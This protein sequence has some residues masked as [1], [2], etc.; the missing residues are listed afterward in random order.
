MLREMMMAAFS[1]P[2]EPIAYVT[3]ATGSALSAGST[4]VTVPAHAA[5]DM[6]IAF[7]AGQSGIPAV[8]VGWTSIATVSSTA[9]RHGRAV[10]KIGSGNSE[11]V[12]FASGSGSS[13]SS[14]SSVVVLRN[15]LGIGAVAVAQNNN[16]GSTTITLPALALQDT[17]GKSMV[18]G[19]NFSAAVTGAGPD[20]VVSG[21]G[22]WR[23]VTSF[24]ATTV[25]VG[26]SWNPIGYSI[27]LL[28]AGFPALGQVVFT[29]SGTWTPPPGVTSFCAVAVQRGGAQGEANASKVTV[30]GT[31][32]LRA[33]NGSRIGQGGGDGGLG[34]ASLLAS[35][36]SSG[37]YPGG[38]T[39][40]DYGGGGAAGYAGN[41]GRGGRS[42]QN[43]DPTAGSGGG[44]GGGGSDGSVP[45]DGGGVGLYGQAASGA[46]AGSNGPGGDGSPPGPFYGVG[47]GAS[48]GGDGRG[49]ALAWANDLACTPGVGVAVQAVSGNGTAG[50]VRIIWGGGRSFPFNAGDM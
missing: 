49:G 46:A 32:V 38:G 15:V 28:G 17:S 42:G 39:D 8:P 50:A 3:S 16:A 40:Y 34:G 22:L 27:E 18:L 45:G 35:I 30:G 47:T 44:G 48:S 37:G 5:G 9:G 43:I 23:G 25:T 1:A 19:T 7:G 36:G 2:P 26:A 4:S 14:Y 6:L 41:G 33:L 21:V 29:S 10:Y 24:P 13:G 12:T 31:V 11:T 20:R